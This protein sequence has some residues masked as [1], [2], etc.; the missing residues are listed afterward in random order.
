MQMKRDISFDLQKHT[1]QDFIHRTLAY[2]SKILSSSI[3]L[4][5]SVSNLPASIGLRHAPDRQK[6]LYTGCY[7][8]NRSLYDLYRYAY[9]N[10]MRF[11]ANRV[12]IE[13]QNPERFNTSDAD[14]YA[15]LPER[16]SYD[17]TVRPTTFD[18]L[19][20]AVRDDLEKTFNVTVVKERRLIP[21]YVVYTTTTAEKAY[22]TTGER[23]ARLD[24][25]DAKKYVT[26]YPLSGFLQFVN[27][28]YF[29]IPLIDGTGYKGNISLN[30]A[31]TL[32]QATI[33][34]S[35]RQAGFIVE[36]QKR[37]MDVAVIINKSST[38]RP[39]FY[40]KK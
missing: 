37:Y 11:A 39:D 4:S 35:I 10:I 17:I 18:S 19:L 32:S 29:K 5:G 33:L 1:L 26:N 8:V 30:L 12:F 16:Y 13:A 15:G 3:I 40:T 24:K 14:D 36:K 7:M 38:G 23:I 28:R 34:Q 25:I 9:R 6:N 20:S 22:A 2:K 31:D 27:Q 21:C